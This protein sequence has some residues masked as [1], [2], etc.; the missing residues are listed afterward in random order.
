MAPKKKRNAEV[1][2]AQPV[3]QLLV[4]ALAKCLPTPDDPRP[5]LL[6]IAGPNGSGKT[7][8]FEIVRQVVVGVDFV[9]ADLIGK[10]FGNAPAP[11]YLAQKIADLMRE[12]Y[13]PHPQSFATETVFSDEKGAKLDYLERAKAAGYHVVMVYVAIPS[14]RLS[15]ARVGARVQNGG[16]AVPMDKLPR[17]YLASMENGRRALR[18]VETGILLDNSFD[19]ATQPFRLMATTSHGRVTYQADQLPDHIKRL[20][21]DE[22]TPLQGEDDPTKNPKPP[23]T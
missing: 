13:L 23:G 15:M 12:H 2:E 14:A 16:H 22:L 9:N 21:P 18:F 1:P 4:E 3:N 5:I 19:L 10:L 17:R 7:S 20:L 6:F 8:L 11:E